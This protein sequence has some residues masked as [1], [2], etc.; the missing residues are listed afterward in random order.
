MDKAKVTIG[1]AV[2]GPK[3]ADKL[4]LV[5]KKQRKGRKTLVLQSNNTNQLDLFDDSDIESRQTV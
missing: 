2:Y 3:C 4:G 1:R 5:E